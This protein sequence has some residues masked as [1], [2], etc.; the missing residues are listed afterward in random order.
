M[1]TRFCH[2]PTPRLWRTRKKNGENKRQIQ[3][4]TGETK[5]VGERGRRATSTISL[6]LNCLFSNKTN[7]NNQ[8]FKQTNKTN[9]NSVVAKCLSHGFRFVLFSVALTGVF[10]YTRVNA[11]VHVEAATSS[12]LNFQARLYGSS[13]ST[14]AD[15]TYHVEFKLH[16]HATNAAGAQG[17]CSG[18]C[19][20][21][22]T[23]TT[24]N[25]VT[26]K[27]G[28][29][30]V[31]LGSVTS[32]PNL[33]WD[34]DMW[35]SMNIGGTSGPTWDGEMTPRIKLTSVPYA[36]RSGGITSYNG[37]QSGNLSFNTVANSPDIKLPDVAGTNNVLLQSGVTLFTQGSITFTDSTGRL[38]QDN[39]SFF[40]DDSTNRLGLLDNTPTYA[41]TV[42][43]GDLF[44]VQSDGT[45]IW[46]GT[47]A[48]AFE[49]IL[50]VQDPDSDLIFELPGD[51]TTGTHEI[52]TSANNCP[53]LAGYIQNNTTLQSNA[54]FNIQSVADGSITAQIRARASQSADLLQFRNSADTIAL[55]GFSSNGSLYFTDPDGT[56]TTTIRAANN[57]LS[58]NNIID[59]PNASGEICTTSGN[60][61]GN[62]GAG[63]VYKNGQ[64]GPLVIGTNDN[65]SV[66]LESNNTSRV[67]IQG[68]GDVFVGNSTRI[69][70]TA[71][72]VLTG[73]ID[74]IASTA[75]TGVGTL[76]TTELTVGDRITVTGETRTVT[77][78]TDNLNLTVDTAFSDNTN[79]TSVDR[80]PAAFSVR[81][82]A[83]AVK[84]VV[85]D[86]GSV[87]IGVTAPG[88]K[89][90]VTATGGGSEKA[91]IVNNSTSTGNILEIQDNGTPVFT[92]AD[93]GL[94]SFTQL[95]TASNDT[96]L[97]RNGSNQVAACNSTFATTANAFLQGGNTFSGT[98]D[99]DL[100]T[101]NNGNLNLR[102]N[103]ATR[104]TVTTAGDL[105]FAQ[106]GNRTL[107]VV[108]ASSGAGNNLTVAAGQGAAS[109]GAG[110]V[111]VLQGGA[112]GGTNQN[113]GNLTIDGGVAT[114][115]GTKGYVVL[116]GT[117]GNVGIGTSNPQTALN[118]NGGDFNVSQ[119]TPDPV[120]LAPGANTG[121]TFSGASGTTYFYKVTAVNGADETLASTEVSIPSTYFTP[122][123][124]PGAPT[125]AD[126]GAG[127]I[128]AGTYYYKV[129]FVTANGETTGG[130]LSSSVA[131][132]ASRQVSLTAVPTG[133]TG[134]TARRIYRCDIPTSGTNTCQTN[135]FLKV[136]SDIADNVTTTFTDNNAA[137]G[138]AIPTANSARVDTNN[139][140]VT[141][142]TITGA[143][144][145]RVYRS[146]T[147]GSGY[148]WQSTA[149]SPFTDTGATG[150]TANPP[151]T[152]TFDAT[153]SSLL[154]VDS[155]NGRIGIGTDAPTHFVNIAPTS[156]SLRPLQVGGNTTNDIAVGIAT[157]IR[158]STNPRMLNLQ[159]TFSPTAAVGASGVQGI[160][161]INSI[162]NSAFN[163]PQAL[164]VTSRID[165]AS[166]YSGVINTVYGYHA[167]NPII[168]GGS[169]RTYIGFG[170]AV[171]SPANVVNVVGMQILNTSSAIGN[172]INLL[173]GDTNPH[174]V[175]GD[176]SI[177]NSSTK[178]NYFAGN[179]GIGDT[180]P[181]ALFTVGNN[182][183]FQ[184]SSTGTVLAKN[185]TNSSTAYQF[186]NAAGA[187]ILAVDTTLNT[188]NLVTNPSLEVDTTGWAAKGAAT[189]TRIISDKYSGN[190]SLQIAT[191]AAASDGAKYNV[192]LA[193]S[194]RHTVSFYAKATGSNF[195]TLAFGYS[196]DGSTEATYVS[197]ANTVTTAGWTR[198]SYTFT[199][200]TN[201]GTP[202]I[203]IKQTDATGRTFYVDA[204]QIEAS[205][206]AS[207][208]YEGQLTVQKLNTSDIVIT[209]GVW[210]DVRAYG[211]KGDG[212]TDDT[213]AIQA[214][215][216]AANAAGGGK[217]FLPAGTY[218]STTLTMPSKVTLAG[219][220]IETTIIQSK[221]TTNVDLIKG[222]DFDSLTGT[223]NTGGIY[224]F[225]IE[226]ITLDGNKANN[227]T[228]GYGVRVYGYDFSMDNVR[229]RNFRNDGLYSEW[230]DSAAP[231][232]P[233]GME[234]R[235][236]NVVTHNNAGNGIKWVGPHDSIWDQV[237]S[238]SNGTTS[239]GIWIGNRANGMQIANS[240]SYGSHAY[241]WYIESLTHLNNSQGE[242][243][244][245]AQVMVGYSNSEIVGGVFF[246]PSGNDCSTPKG[247]QIGDG[248]HTG[249]S[250]VHID[251]T[252]RDLNGGSIEFGSSNGYNRVKALVYQTSGAAVIGTPASTDQLDIDVSGG[253]TGAIHNTG[254]SGGF[255]G[256]GVAAPTSKL[257]VYQSST[258]TSGSIYNTNSDLNI[259]PGS[260]S[261]ANYY[262]DYNFAHAASGLV[263]DL[264][265]QVTGS[266][267]TAYSQA[268]SGRTIAKLIG[269]DF[270][271]SNGGLGTITQNIGLRVNTSNATTGTIG[272][273]YGILINNPTN[274]GTLT[275]NFGLQIS[276]Q[277]S[278]TNNVGLLIAEAT[279]TKNTNLLIGTTTVPAGSYSIYNSSADQ[280][281]F[282]GNLG[283]GV[284]VPTSPLHV[285]KNYANGPTGLDYNIFTSSTV[286]GTGTVS[287]RRTG[288]Q[289]YMSD[290]AGVVQI[291]VTAASNP[292]LI[293][294]TTASAHG[295]TTGD[296]ITV[297]GVGGNTAANGIWYITVTG[298]STFTLDGSTANGA[299]TSGG[300]VTNRSMY[301]AIGATVA[302]TVARGGLTGAAANGDDVN[303]VAIYNNGTA[304]ATDALYVSNN[305]SIVGDAWAT[306]LTHD[307]AAN[308]GIR[309]NGT[310]S[311]S[312][313]DLTAST[314]AVAPIKLKNNTSIVWRN[315][316]N[317]ANI[318]GIAVDGSDNLSLRGGALLVNS[319]GSLTFGAASTA[320]VTSAAAQDLTIDSGTTG[321][322]NIGTGASAKTIN[323]GNTTGATTLNFQSGSGGI[324][325][326][327]SLAGTIDTST[328]LCRNSTNQLT[329]CLTTGTGAAFVQGGNDFGAD[330]VLGTNGAGQSLSFET[331]GTTK[332]TVTSAGDLTFAQGANR[333]LNVATNATA[334]GAGYNLTLAAGAA[335]GTAAGNVGGLL[336][337]QGGA[338]AGSGNNR[339]GNIY[340]YG[341]SP[342]GTSTAGDVILAYNGTSR[343]GNV[344]IG[345]STPVSPF[346]T[347]MNV[348]ISGASQ[349]NLWFHTN[350][351]GSTATDGLEIQYDG[352][353][354]YWWNYENSGLGFATNNTQR[355][356]ISAG[357]TTSV[358]GGTTGH[359]LTVTNS[360][361]TG[362]IAVFR[363]NFADV[364][365]ISDG[366]AMILQNV[367]DSTAAF[368][369]NR[370][371]T[372]TTDVLKVDTTNSQ[373]TLRGIN[374]NATTGSNLVTSLDFTSA[375]WT[376]CNGGAGG[377][378][379]TAS[380]AAHNTGNTVACSAAA[381]NFTVTA[382]TT[383]RIGFTL[384]GN[385]TATDTVTTSIGGVSGPAIGQTGT[386]SHEMVIT[387]STT[388]ALTFTPTTN[389][390]GTISSVTVQ[391]I[392]LSNAVL[393]LKNSSNTTALELRA[394]NTS[395]LFIGLDAGRSNQVQ[396][397]VNTGVGTGVLQANTVG[398]WNTGL[399]Y[400]AL[401][402]NTTGINNTAIGYESLYS[403]TNGVNNT[404]IGSRALYGNTN[405]YYN[406]AFGGN[407]LFSNV[408]GSSNTA[409][410][411]SAMSANTTGS[412]NTAIG[413]YALSSNT[414]GSN[415][416][417]IGNSAGYQ[418]PTVAS[419]VTLG[420]LTN[421]TVLGYGA[422]V[423]ASN[424]LI[425]GGQGANAVNVGIGTTIPTNTLSVSPMQY[426]TGTASQSTTTVTGI[427][428]TFTAAMV[429]SE[430]IFANG[431]KAT[432]TA[433]GSTTSLTVT[434]SQTVSAQDYRIHYIGLQVTSA[435][436]VGIGS[437]APGAK[438]EV[439]TDSG[440]SQK[441]LVV[442]NSTSTGNIL[443]VQDNGTPV[444]TIADGGN[445]TATGTYNT[446]TF[447]GNTLTFGSASATA[448][449]SAAGQD[450]TIDSGTTGAVNI[451]TGGTAKTVTVGNTTG[452]TGIVINTG[453]NGINI[454][455]NANTKTTDIGGN[456]ANGV[457][458]VRIATNATS[459]DTITIGS[460]HV[461]SV[462]TF[463]GG[464]YNLNIR[465]TGIG[466]NATAPTTGTVDLF[467]GSG[468]RTINVNQSGASTAGGALTINAG[469]SGTGAVNGGDLIL[470]AG[471][472]GGSG[473]TG[474]VI[475]KANGTNSTTA[476]Q[477]Q[478]S[479]S[480]V[481]LAADT[482]NRLIKIGTGTPGITSAATGG[483]Y[484]T[485]SFEIGTGGV[486]RIG[487]GTNG[488]DFTAGT[489]PSSANPF[490]KGTS[491][492]TKRVSLVPEFAGAVMTGDGTSNTGTMTTDFCSASALK[493]INPSVCATAGDEHNYYS[494][495]SPSGT[496]DYDIYVRYQ[497]PS[498]FDGFSASDTINMFGWRSTT[499]DKVELAV[500]NAAG[501][502]CGSTTDIN[503]ANGSPAT[504][505]WQETP[506]TGSENTDANCNTTNMAP[507]SVII[508]RIRVTATSANFARAGGI[509]FEYLSKF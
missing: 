309:L 18:S 392:T 262:G 398:D 280:N 161:N 374:S 13:G 503:A 253:A 341:G 338:A 217:V 97:C 30:S 40:F 440:G 4:N 287:Q 117:G 377:W 53:S 438:L 48:D 325:I 200:G 437:T 245:T 107:N 306:V 238:Y 254:L 215:L 136:G 242:G 399:G 25:L 257:H 64:A 14:V 479:N 481:L 230:A 173:L 466:I 502:Q 90:H 442:N 179:L 332:L 182:D 80:L 351:S 148:N 420:N 247:I 379:G 418:D 216:D 387:A 153:G 362:N 127:S 468:A 473:T 488:I 424:S 275:D 62:G 422:Q 1:S 196:H 414:T 447:N 227:A 389:F 114:G 385:T 168:A 23:R 441:T 419:F 453:T 352:S 251:T 417:A 284:T 267:N 44:G 371:T 460:T 143:T 29:F 207:S 213:V 109:N 125:V 405:G 258:A 265:G 5:S 429:G 20:W 208:F 151:V 497:L 308:Y 285:V 448:I 250:K 50:R 359:A 349:A 195:S 232:G 246:C 459:A 336:T 74:P 55:S 368:I 483:M 289:S 154:R 22:E 172:D 45:I 260:A 26:V 413:D 86:Q 241:S 467:F 294:I 84:V 147:S 290:G 223:A 274:A 397:T 347:T 350:G 456:D 490:F 186:Q 36:F 43:N 155:V 87:G 435:G 236:Q 65:T 449:S 367:T 404:A 411:N 402:N 343:V 314:S 276:A 111:L 58:G 403:N 303:G 192:S 432:I 63:D 270:V 415:N 493:N 176:Y 407:A 79:D 165:T 323:L 6:S 307:G 9:L 426:N 297:E 391:P 496:N 149:S 264:T 508:F 94:V 194:T 57:S 214:A 180:T 412:T 464:A 261:S 283:I 34:Q 312:A 33:N 121:G 463:N 304:R 509:R 222:K 174:A 485:N 70:A 229:I 108:Q 24:G 478:Q 37:T 115:S 259:N 431:S 457:D 378:S 295:F 293:A 77:S 164:G 105:T 380:N 220:G 218:I 469:M 427:D 199:N 361:S 162:A 296:K 131:I 301:N 21:R 225:R 375:N 41:L 408:T 465:N 393:Q 507:N 88:S 489:A 239:K 311:D 49:T 124:P 212:V 10:L 122:L 12:T 319:A 492:P 487:D 327:A 188:L 17:A 330:A 141:F 8:M 400:R 233:N 500:F 491:R 475:I 315:A 19:L 256:V 382:G 101:N 231:P 376:S 158:S 320:L 240:H 118:V 401:F 126:G 326:P 423:Q 82:S 201:S 504:T 167:G 130:T 286:Q 178:Q 272:T 506:M 11:P 190:A 354:G 428:T 333:T 476:F 346:A 462:A 169:V 268:G 39:V 205:A 482:T 183:L 210:F 54:N 263:A 322:L 100:G 76:F 434:P 244:T 302:P 477:I 177:Y 384:A 505:T 211:A 444:F 342:T 103:N 15:G 366:G 112:G 3:I 353:A 446:N 237:V 324:V 340:A 150:T 255:L 288:L 67:E 331:A 451:A 28:Y 316:A 329:T 32:F 96:V 99:G 355:L 494:W 313:I 113:G 142:K 175:G 430:I 184:V 243:A 203:F 226:N 266:L 386:N 92:I 310:Y 160:S 60:C 138:A 91:F 439:K 47:D 278:G 369:V 132:A 279:G 249:V 495:T 66:Y 410:G 72:A 104:L 501:G 197:S 390:N 187:N 406:T 59:L 409:L 335:D 396:G 159:G 458:T 282:A 42:G 370:V 75:V 372:S 388:G 61:L 156:T 209:S 472:T 356:A 328:Y 345:T 102:T 363:D 474:S 339:G 373:T 433:F 135:G 395:N 269:G 271:A 68:D 480:N 191:T 189:L 166:T 93:G 193:N 7:L 202:Y 300:Y 292:G 123:T 498:D 357:G 145:Y 421:A 157:T 137:G 252:M 106:G 318:Q 416:T 2:P 470:Q 273:N 394:G 163:I 116:Q 381:G 78:I 16:D 317:S 144:G 454:G 499:S 110:G 204:V 364:V 133:P 69:T 38:T 450:L 52:C 98:T 181:A 281:Y 452:S 83:G 436:L 471:A 89:L 31:N 35:L 228:A 51:V 81:D 152:A 358:E 277:T 170:S 455:D 129:S 146:T 425:L 360:T 73:S 221:S 198:Y 140:T 224:A 128:A 46:E 219:S 119:K 85:N 383:Y 206:N 298:A 120:L 171:A 235:M 299:Y 484:V 139:V 95:G 443:E 445:I 461:S 56:G 486:L 71:T 305:P 248:T 334:N 291:N 344:G 185:S 234:A 134:T 337:L 321:T 27:N 365:T 348:D